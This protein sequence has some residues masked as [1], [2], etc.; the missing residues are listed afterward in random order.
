MCQCLIN[1]CEPHLPGE[2][3]NV[4]SWDSVEDFEERSDVDVLIDED[5]VLVLWSTLG[6]S[7]GEEMGLVDSWSA[8][9]RKYSGLLT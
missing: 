6:L 3:E 5:D 8:M 4:G 7:V 1:D 2:T 9:E